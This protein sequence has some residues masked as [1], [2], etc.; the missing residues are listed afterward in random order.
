MNLLKAQ[1][2]IVVLLLAS[3]GAFANSE[4]EARAEAVSWLELVDDG[5]YD[6]SWDRAASLFRSKVSR[7]QWRN[8]VISARGPFGKLLSRNLMSATYAT[9]L[10]GAPD[11]EYVVLVFEASYENADSAVE[12]V[13]PMKDAGQWRVSGYYIR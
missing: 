10:P 8:A 11:G 1:F 4:E 7:Q 5:K 12:T 2:L 3:A 9:R 13:T 6:E